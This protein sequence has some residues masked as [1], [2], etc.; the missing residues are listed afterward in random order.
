MSEEDDEYDEY[1]NEP[2]VP[3]ATARSNKQMMVPVPQNSTGDNKEPSTTIE[4]ERHS[5]ENAGITNGSGLSTYFDK[6]NYAASTKSGQSAVS[7]NIGAATY[8]DQ[9]DT[10]LKHLKTETKCHRIYA[11]F[12]L[13]DFILQ[14]L[15]MTLLIIDYLNMHDRCSAKTEDITQCNQDTECNY[16]TSMSECHPTFN[17]NLLLIIYIA[18]FVLSS[19]NWVYRSCVVCYVV[20]TGPRNK[21]LFIKGQVMHQVYVYEYLYIVYHHIFLYEYKYK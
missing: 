5:S 11:H 20:R 3:L 15:L 18:V 13:L 9:M 21:K 16:N 8:F 17:T 10:S 2:I 7:S 6:P 19:F 14:C 1:G 4:L 12:N